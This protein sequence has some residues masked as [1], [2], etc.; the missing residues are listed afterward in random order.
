[1][2]HVGFYDSLRAELEPNGEF[3]VTE[4]GT[5]KD[6]K[7]FA[8]LYAYSPYHRVVDGTKYPAV[9]FL[10][11]ETDGRVNPAN[12][13][14]MTARL[15]AA[16]TSGLPIL[17]RQSS[18]SGHGMGTALS[19]EIAQNADVFAFLFDQLGMKKAK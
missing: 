18:D 6:P 1:V 9:F 12:S 16:T 13:R 14:K 10:A 5:V 7:Q 3:N 17:L 19:E 2:S 4:F 15:Q 11:G 8:A